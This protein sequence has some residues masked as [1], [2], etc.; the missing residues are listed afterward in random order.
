[1]TDIDREF[2]G[3]P[4]PAIG[5]AGAGGHPLQGIYYTPAGR[6]PK[7]ALIAAHYNVDFSEHYIATRMAERGYGFLGWNTRFRGA[8][9]FFILDHA[10]AEIG[11][12]VSWLRSRGVEQVVLLGNS[13]GGSLMTAYHSQSREPNIRPPYGRDHV[14]E[15]ALHLPPADLM[16]FLAAHPGR[17]EWITRTMDPS[18]LDETDPN[19]VD[20]EL[21]MYDPAHG[22]SYS[23][24]FV[25]R[26]R[27]AQVARNDRLTA[28][29]KEQLAAMADRPAR[30]RIFSMPRTWA[31]L[32]YLDPTIDPS[33]R[34]TPMCYFGDPKHANYGVFGVGVVS[35]MRTWLNM[36]SLQESDCV[37]AKHLQRL[38]LPTLV[39][40]PDADTGVFPSDAQGLYDGAVSTDKEL[41]TLPGDH[42]FVEPADA[43]DVV[44]DTLADWL[45]SRTSR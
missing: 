43:R 10:L 31:D 6:K 3:L 33:N 7:T 25:A 2:I 18:V 45:A 8:E 1:M 40:Q 30:D 29:C 21:D 13:G 15:P 35:T 28:W 19:S 44:A 11:V 24:Q 9:H 42:Y 26:Y 38:D 12:G 22:P 39:V 27:A 5:R 37:A 41:V 36:F 34:P 17:P 20:P 16:I 4:S 14:F 32:R 23:P